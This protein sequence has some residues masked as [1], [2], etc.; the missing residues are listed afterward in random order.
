MRYYT[1]IK[2]PI[3]RY[4]AHHFAI[5]QMHISFAIMVMFHYYDYYGIMHVYFNIM[6]IIRYVSLL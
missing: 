2:R 6:T 1:T 4:Y 5:I 3:K